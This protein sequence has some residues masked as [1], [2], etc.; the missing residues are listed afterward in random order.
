M[1]SG[2]DYITNLLASCISVGKSN[3]IKVL[4]TPSV[5]CCATSGLIGFVCGNCYVHEFM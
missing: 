3:K 2:L 4:A 5:K 1:S